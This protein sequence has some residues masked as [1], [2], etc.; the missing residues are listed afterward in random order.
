MA[1]WGLFNG[2]TIVGCVSQDGNFS[3]AT[4]SAMH[5]AAQALGYRTSEDC[6]P[7]I[8]NFLIDLCDGLRLTILSEPPDQPSM[9]DG[10]VDILKGCLGCDAHAGANALPT[11]LG[12]LS[13]MVL[14]GILLMAVYKSGR[15]RQPEGTE[16]ERQ[17]LTATGNPA[18][19]TTP[20]A[21]A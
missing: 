1:Q 20:P 15:C 9:S 11:V 5:Q 19:S 8:L 4:V 14:V 16:A 10:Q 3:N 12:V 17:Q 18:Y 21:H 2:S 13:A 6:S 7:N